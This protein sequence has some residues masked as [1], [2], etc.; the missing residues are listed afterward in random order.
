MGGRVKNASAWGVGGE[1]GERRGERGQGSGNRG[2]GRGEGLAK[3]NGRGRG[4]GMTGSYNIGHDVCARDTRNKN[5][6]K[7]TIQ[8][9]A[10]SKRDT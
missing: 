8:R 4:G 1:R 3:G 9:S 5:A 2:E 7:D 10:W 6:Y